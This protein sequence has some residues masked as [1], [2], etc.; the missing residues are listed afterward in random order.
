ML[1]LAQ[2]RDEDLCPLCGWPKVICQDPMTEFKAH[3]L[4]P[5]RCQITTTI[6]R[7]QAEWGEKANGGYPEAML[8]GAQVKDPTPSE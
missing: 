4:P 2:W 3:T 1:A 5:V 8:W 6:N 7:A